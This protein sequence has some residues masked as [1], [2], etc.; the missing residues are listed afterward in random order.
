MVFRASKERRRKDPDPVGRG[1]PIV[2]SAAI[3]RKYK[4]QIDSFVIAMMADYREQLKNAFENP[5]VEAFYAQDATAAGVFKKILKRLDEKWKNVFEGFASK[6]SREFAGGVDTAAT[7]TALHSLSVAG[8]KEPKAM[9]N[10]YVQNTLEAAIDFNHTLIVNLQQ[11]AHEKIYTSVML[12][13]SSPNP[14]EQGMTAIENAVKDA[15]IDAKDRVKLIARDQTSKLYSA[16]AD[17]RCRENGVDEYEWAHSSAGKVP[18]E[19][20]KKMDGHIFKL[21]DP[22]LW[23]TGG[24]FDL[25]K[26]DLGPP[27]WAIN[28]RCRRIP[29]IR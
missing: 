20:H 6:A 29:I 11:E 22:R 10:Q 23:Q 3:E 9:F 4:A 15:G 28:C 8:V 5:D 18:R 7:A 25:K 26:G 16:L 27:G 17:D 14:D 24:E 2:P 21:D 12:S 1:T 13:L 19:S